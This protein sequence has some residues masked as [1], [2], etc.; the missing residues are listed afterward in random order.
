MKVIQEKILD[1]LIDDA[2][3]SQRLRKNLNI[4][5]ELD[6]PVQR[7]CNAFEPGTYVR[8]HRHPQLGRWE[9]FVILKG[10]ADVLLFD[11]DGQ[12]TERVCLSSQ[13]P[14]Y[15]VEI[16]P[17]AWHTLISLQSGTVLFEVKQG[18]YQALSDKD[19]ATWAPAENSEAAT[20]LLE[21]FRQ[22][23]VGQRAPVLF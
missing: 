12:V 15:I 23:S 14:A 3:S 2:K 6:D 20:E 8:P 16:P 18:P 21:W 1:Q 17:Q 22:C 19:F 11:Q 7:L 9:L 10:R 4:H 5:A 13:G